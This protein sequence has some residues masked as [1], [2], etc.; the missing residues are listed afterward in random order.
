M[1]IRFVTRFTPQVVTTGTTNYDCRYSSSFPACGHHVHEEDLNW[2]RDIIHVNSPEPHLPGNN[3]STSV[4]ITSY[5]E[6]TTTSMCSAETFNMSHFPS[7]GFFSGCAVGNYSVQVGN[8]L[9]E[10]TT[11]NNAI[12]TSPCNLQAIHGT[13]TTGY[14]IQV[15]HWPCT[16]STLP[17]T[18]SPAHFA[19]SFTPILSTTTAPYVSQVPANT[20]LPIPQ[21]H[22]KQTEVRKGRNPTGK[23]RSSRVPTIYTCDYENCGRIYTKSTHFKTHLRLHTGEKPYVCDWPGCEWKFPR[24]DELTRHFRKHTGLR[25]FLCNICQRTF[26]RS[27][28]LSL[29]VKRH[30]ST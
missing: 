30:E 13:G 6:H 16:N 7:E 25:P 22:P 23:Q 9:S 4:P 18:A 5:C 28:H 17:Y 15:L 3:R 2:E 11:L 26:A 14:Q 19:S 24:S 21:V 12:N 20:S 10:D 8:N 1:L 27:D 29:H